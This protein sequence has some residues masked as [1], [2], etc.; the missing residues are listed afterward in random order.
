[1]HIKIFLIFFAFLILLG[2][3]TVSPCQM[4]KSGSFLGRTYGIDGY[5]GKELCSVVKGKL[6]VLCKK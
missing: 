1:M 6:C 2:I 4:G 5:R 3:I